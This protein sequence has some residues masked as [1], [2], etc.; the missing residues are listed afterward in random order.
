MPSGKNNVQSIPPPIYADRTEEENAELVH[1]KAA[2]IVGLAGKV[3]PAKDY[4]YAFTARLAEGLKHRYPKDVEDGAPIPAPTPLPGWEKFGPKFKTGPWLKAERAGGECV[5]IDLRRLEKYFK[6]TA[7][8][9]WSEVCDFP[10]AARRELENTMA[11]VS[12]AA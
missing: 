10:R 11:P 6:D 12:W 5:V 3:D 4:A 1:A 8:Q 7:A 2:G 9:N